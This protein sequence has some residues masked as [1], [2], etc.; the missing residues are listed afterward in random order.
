[1]VTYI[2]ALYKS[3]QSIL[4]GWKPEPGI[5]PSASY[6]VYVGTNDS[7]VSLLASGIPNIVDN[8]PVTQGRISYKA[9]LS[10]VLAVTSL[11][12]VDFTNKVFYFAITDVVNGTESDI[13]NSTVVEVPPVG[14]T[15]KFM[16]D[17]PTMN[18]HGFVFNDDIQRWVKMA[19]SPSGATV[20]D[21]ADFYKSNITTVYNYDGTN[22]SSTLSYLSD[23]TTSGSAAKLTTYSYSGSQL[24]K[25]VVTDS[26][27][28]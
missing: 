11:S 6:N 8:F 4:F 27:V 16:K 25:V 23:E 26:T 14:I 9:S 17:D 20:T 10:S 24:T 28:S 15:S 7:T 5:G 19:G 18:R 2:E 13:N 12:N 21:S 22:L 3:P 1:M